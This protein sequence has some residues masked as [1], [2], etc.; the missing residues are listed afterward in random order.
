MVRLVNRSAKGKVIWEMK[1]S[2][3][4]ITYVGK[5]AITGLMGG[6]STGTTFFVLAVGTGTTAEAP[7]QTTLSSEIITSG[8]SR[9]TAVI[10]QVTTTSTNDTM[11]ASYTWTATGTQTIQEV[12]IFSNLS[13]GTSVMLGRKLTGT[14]TVNNTEQ[15]TAT[16]DIILS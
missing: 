13:I 12:G 4:V 16:Y 14:K 1:R 7:T 11:Q 8:L 3:N 2:H 9:N 6:L 10:T 15:L 5:A